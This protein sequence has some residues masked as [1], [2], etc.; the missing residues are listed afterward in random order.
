[1]C[2]FLAESMGVFDEPARYPLLHAH[3]AQGEALPDFRATYSRW[4][5]AAVKQ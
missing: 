4:F 3:N 1:M 2:T 5:M